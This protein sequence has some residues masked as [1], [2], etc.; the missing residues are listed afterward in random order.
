MAQVSFVKACIEFFSTGKYGRKVEIK[1]FQK[2]T[3]KDKEDLRT[4]LINEVGLDVAE[5]PGT[6]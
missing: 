2:L 3:R 1:E 5:I 6:S 4:L